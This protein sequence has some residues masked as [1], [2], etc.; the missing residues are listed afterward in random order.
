MHAISGEGGERQ[1]MV[2]LTTSQTR[3]LEEIIAAQASAR[4]THLLTGYAGS[5]KTTLMQAVARHFQ[6]QNL[7]VVITAPT[8]KAT[9]VLRSKVDKEMDCRTIQSLLSLQPSAQGAKTSLVRSK[10]PQTIADDVVIVDEC[11]MLSAELMNWIRELLKY[12]FVLFVGDPA[13][14]PPVG[15]GASPSFSV[16]SR[17]HLDTVVRQAADNPI[18]AA[19]T[20]IRKN[21]G[22][23]P[24][25][26][27]VKA[28]KHGQ[29]GLFVPK[30]TESWLRKAFLSEAFDADNDW[31][32]YLCWTNERASQVN[33]MIRRWRY[34]DDTPTPFMPGERVVSRSPV[35][36]Q[37]EE[38]PRLCIVTNE[39][40]MVLAIRESRL[41]YAFKT[42]G[43]L[44]GW[45]TNIPFWEITLLSSSGEE[46]TA[47]MPKDR[48]DVDA[49]DRRLVREAK[50]QH[51][52]WN[53]RFSFLNSL[54]KLQPIYAMTVH[55]SQG[56]TFTNAFID[57]SDIGRR[58]SENPLEKQQLCYVAI[59]R[60]TDM[61]F[62]VNTRGISHA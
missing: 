41:G 23:A 1:I 6:A 53:Q 8:H 27:W 17:S 60:A 11:S 29:L 51:K 28:A 40:V 50:S 56:S 22:N 31:C 58:A 43:D 18:L 10:R 52:R 44:P 32:R 42:C 35:S 48:R 33:Q 49:A 30:D 14:L 57:L 55:T 4:P 9:A 47:H 46:V 2:A 38:G 16:P 19:A 62:L 34:G 26:G 20:A 15:E 5:G 3:A 59:T 54:L 37:S 24:D 13:Q 36:R 45:S 21:Q 39:E 61:V 7:V 12:C 25:W